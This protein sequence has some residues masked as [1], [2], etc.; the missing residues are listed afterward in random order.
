MTNN[1]CSVDILMIIPSTLLRDLNNSQSLN[2]SKLI[3][4]GSIG[5]FMEIKL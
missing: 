3:K 5:I 2:Y 4:S 1:V